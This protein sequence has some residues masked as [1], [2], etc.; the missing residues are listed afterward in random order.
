MQKIN[1]FRQHTLILSAV[2][3]TLALVSERVF[4]KGYPMTRSPHATVLF[5]GRMSDVKVVEIAAAHSG[6]ALPA[7]AVE[8]L[9]HLLGGQTS[10]TSCLVLRTKLL[11]RKFPH[12]RTFGVVVFYGRNVNFDQDTELALVSAHVLAL[13]KNGKLSLIRIQKNPRGLSQREI[14]KRGLT[15]ILPFV[16]VRRK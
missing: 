8:Q 5:H 16:Q 15:H 13:D 11:Q 9:A 14:R 1:A 12:C 6:I 7:N 4:A 2:F 3:L 10:S